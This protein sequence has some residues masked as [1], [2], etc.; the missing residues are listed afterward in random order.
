LASENLQYTVFERFRCKDRTSP[1]RYSNRMRTGYCN[2][3]ISGWCCR[4]RDEVVGWMRQRLCRL[5][6]KLLS[7]PPV[8]QRVRKELLAWIH[9]CS[10]GAKYNELK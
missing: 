7:S 3:C 5:W 2:V 8:C 10:E 6:P 1:W 9:G 4:S